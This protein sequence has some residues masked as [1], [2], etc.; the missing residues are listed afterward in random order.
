MMTSINLFSR[1]KEKG[2]GILLLTQQKVKTGFFVKIGLR[3]KF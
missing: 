3:K 1:Q 2:S